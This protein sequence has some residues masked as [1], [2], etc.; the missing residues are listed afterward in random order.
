LFQRVAETLL[1]HFAA[2]VEKTRENATKRMNK[3]I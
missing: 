3:R 1:K 2:K